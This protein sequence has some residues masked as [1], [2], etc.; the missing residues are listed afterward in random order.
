[1]HV[2]HVFQSFVASGQ[3]WLEA[4]PRFR[5]AVRRVITHPDCGSP[6]RPGALSTNDTRVWREVTTHATRQ[7]RSLRVR[8]G[9]GRRT[10][11]S[12]RGGTTGVATLM[13]TVTSARAVRLVSIVAALCGGAAIAQSVT[14]QTAENMRTRD[15]VVMVTFNSGG[16]VYRGSGTIVSP[17]GFILTNHH[18]LTDLE[19]VLH[20][21]V[22][23]AT[24]TG[25]AEV[26]ALRY[27]AELVRSDEQSDLAVLRIV[28]LADGSPLPPDTRFRY[29]PIGD[30]SRLAVGR[31]QLT[32]WGFP[33][34]G[35]SSLT[36]TRGVLS[37][38]VGE[39][40]DAPGDRWIKTDANVN[41]G[42]SGG[43]ALDSFGHLVA[44]PTQR[45]WD[46]AGEAYYLNYLRPVTVARQLL[47]TVP[48]VEYAA[49]IEI[50]PPVDAL[51]PGQEGE[52]VRRAQAG[53][54]IRLGPGTFHLSERLTLSRSVALI[55]AGRTSTTIRGSA[56]GALVLFDGTGS[57]TLSNLTIEYVG[58]AP[59]DVLWLADGTTDLRHV[60]VQGAIEDGSGNRGSG[61]HA[62]GPA[63]VSV[64]DA[65]VTGNGRIGV[66][67]Q[68][69]AEAYIGTSTVELNGYGVAAWGAS[70]VTVDSSALERNIVSNVYVAGN[71]SATIRASSLARPRHNDAFTLQLLPPARISIQTSDVEGLMLL[72]GVGA[73]TQLPYAAEMRDNTFDGI[74]FVNNDGR[75]EFLGRNVRRG[76]P[77]GYLVAC[78][79]NW[80]GTLVG[81]SNIFGSV[82]PLNELCR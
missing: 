8:R 73:G 30:P 45:R 2:M 22:A 28:A 7:P 1:M 3:R 38:W 51:L 71:A 74:V 57:L 24:Q 50:A 82:Q 64:R 62:Y 76:P 59:A 26:A 55:G 10:P 23:I 9:R 21:R 29:L 39:R 5:L 34:V 70:R 78:L 15:A 47:E 18:V 77:D 27:V 46:E 42:N 53:G 17:L 79:S 48:G 12:S 72:G 49:P 40:S 33:V 43:A 37:G 25:V 69:Q 66:A 44:V 81:T 6:M 35:G 19:G 65:R 63:V 41:P 58:T 54:E 52:L 13:R 68:D 75:V 80:T 20:R 14:V 36:A 56:E 11:R 4:V 60:Q 16:Y 32:V 31:D 67:L 61:I